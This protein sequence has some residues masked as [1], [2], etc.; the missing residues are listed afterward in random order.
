MAEWTPKS[1][2]P[3]DDDWIPPSAKT[4]VKAHSRKPRI[5]AAIGGTVGGLAGLVSGPAAP[6]VSPLA[7]T[8]G[9][10]LG[11]A[12]QQG[13]EGPI[14][15]GAS[16]N[17]VGTI[18]QNLVTF[19]SDPQEIAK[20][21]LEQGIA[22]GLGEAG[23]LA[24]KAAGGP[25]MRA[26]L[27]ST[28]EVAQTAIKETVTATKEG[29]K[30]ILGRIGEA[31]ANTMNIVRQATGTGARFD[32]W[33]IEKELF[34]E[35]TAGM[36]GLPGDKARR[37]YVSNLGISFLGENRRT[38]MTPAQLHILKM[39][40][41]EL[42]EP[43][44]RKLN[45]PGGRLTERESLSLRW[46]KGFA[47]KVRETLDPVIPGYREANQATSELIGVK[48]AL[49]KPA[50]QGASFGQRALER[51]ALP[52]AGATIGGGLGMQRGETAGERAAYGAAGAALGGGLATPQALSML[53]LQAQNPIIAQFISSLLRGGRVATD[54]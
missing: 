26:A 51:G 36:K 7:S 29:M 53:A 16:L 13:A 20:Q 5:G 35:M 40:A 2:V 18:I 37:A 46:Y 22:G 43:L 3:V 48:N 41:D 19:G 27:R 14:P 39:R 9:G 50:R 42:A 33:G 1:A 25:L 24:V 6:L 34:N 38:N 17:P 15:L 31:G 23:G 21:G 32:H 12:A 52:A 49:S 45:S 8:A 30:K 47:D 4:P 11:E 10:A 54:Q 28:P 44:Y